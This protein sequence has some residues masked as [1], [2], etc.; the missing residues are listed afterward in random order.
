[1]LVLKLRS[2]LFQPQRGRKNKHRL[3]VILQFRTTLKYLYVLYKKNHKW[4]PDRAHSCIPR[5]SR[6]KRRLGTKAATALLAPPPLLASTRRHPRRHR[7]CSPCRARGT[8][9]RN[10]RRE[11]EGRTQK[12]QEMEKTKNR[13]IG[14]PSNKGRRFPSGSSERPGMYQPSTKSE[15]AVSGS[16]V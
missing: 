9:T 12:C 7:A 4:R 3:N 16:M 6:H 1:M 2:S 14:P 8:R 11:K 15:I 10:E 13:W 5:V